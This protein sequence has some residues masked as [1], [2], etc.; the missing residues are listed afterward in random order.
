MCEPI[1]GPGQTLF[2]SLSCFFNM[3]N[4]AMTEIKLN[5]NQI[6]SKVCCSVMRLRAVQFFGF[7]EVSAL[8]M[9][10]GPD[11]CRH[12]EKGRWFQISS[13]VISWIYA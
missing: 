3:L 11:F 10:P 7:P 4:F 9:L 5:Y 1:V 2:W 12:I 13:N 8:E 6:Q